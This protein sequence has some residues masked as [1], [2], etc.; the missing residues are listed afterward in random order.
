[1]MGR[2]GS[3]KGKLAD[4]PRV[5]CHSFISG[6]VM[7]G[8]RFWWWYDHDKLYISYM[9][10]LIGCGSSV[11]AVPR[12]LFLKLERALYRL[13]WRWQQV[14]RARFWTSSYDV[15]GKFEGIQTCSITHRI[16]V[17][18]IYIYIYLYTNIGGILMVTVTIYSIHG[19]Y[20]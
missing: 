9:I 10:G 19:S 6:Q 3:A 13:L 8:G 7:V 12:R 15:R 20:G 17:W 4:T 14:H 18:Y 11:L 16:H 1:M 2:D 5:F